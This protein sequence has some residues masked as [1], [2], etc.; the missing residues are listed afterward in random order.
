MFNDRKE[1]KLR[2]FYRVG[3]IVGQGAFGEV[4]I[5][6]HRESGSA[7]CIKVLKKKKLNLGEQK[8]LLNEINILKELNHPNI[9]RMFEFFEDE[10][11]YY[12][13]TDFFSGGELFQELQTNGPLSEENTAKI[14][15]Q[16]LSCVNY[17]HNRN[18]T[19]R[20]LKLENILLESSKNY[21]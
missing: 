18:V 11:R 12:L 7:R 16:V 19:H 6:V 8:M 2:D 4:R 17:L 5:C 3:K 15:K 14:V 20:D 10:T 13:I 21:D 1:G 9:V